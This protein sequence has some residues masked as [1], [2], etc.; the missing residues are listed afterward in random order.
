MSCPLTVLYKWYQQNKGF[1]RFLVCFPIHVLSA[2]AA[3]QKAGV[4][5][6]KTKYDIA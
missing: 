6:G 1:L 3:R 5:I 2:L 4:R